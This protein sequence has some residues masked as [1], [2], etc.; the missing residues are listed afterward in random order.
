M[1][2]T[3]FQRTLKAHEAAGDPIIYLDESGFALDMPR[4]YGYAK[5]EQRCYDT[6]NWQAKGRTNVMGALRGKELLTTCLCN[7]S[8]DGP[9]FHA[10]VTQQ[11]LPVLPQQS[12]ILMDNAT[13][14]KRQDTQEAIESNGHCLTYLPPYSPDLN[15][16]EHKWAQAKALR[17]ILHCSVEALFS[18]NN[19]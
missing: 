1:A 2:R 11:L 18:E 17:R 7:T 14:H 16:I 9:I 15:P 12:V 4:R 5:K 8:I 19:L 10:W 6:H 3:Q 13:F